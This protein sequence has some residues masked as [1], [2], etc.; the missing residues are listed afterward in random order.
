MNLDDET[1][2][3][4]KRPPPSTASIRKDFPPF[5]FVRTCVRAGA[6]EERSIAFFSLPPRLRDG[7]GFTVGKKNHIKVTYS[8]SMEYKDSSLGKYSPL[9]FISPKNVC[10][11]QI[12]CELHQLPEVQLCRQRGEREEEKRRRMW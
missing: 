11:S 3:Y 8:K 1:A 2:I 12:L 10:D 4:Q 9:V 7:R 5:F 6:S